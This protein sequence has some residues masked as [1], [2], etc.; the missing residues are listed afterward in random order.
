MAG[1]RS[2][3]PGAFQ[4]EPLDRYAETE[5]KRASSLVK[6]TI[7]EKQRRTAAQRIREAQALRVGSM[8]LAPVPEQPEKKGFFRMNQ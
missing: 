6:M 8:A 5:R 7:A 4:L 3:W 2:G 1:F